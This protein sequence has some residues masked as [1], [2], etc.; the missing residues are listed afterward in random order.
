MCIRSTGVYTEND[1]ESD[2][3]VLNVEYLMVIKTYPFNICIVQKKQ[4]NKK[5]KKK[6]KK[7]KK[8]TQYTINCT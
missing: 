4:N 8:K 5:Q 2:D 6:K 7:K 3:I 1:K